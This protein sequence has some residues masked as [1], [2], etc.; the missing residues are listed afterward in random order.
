VHHVSFGN[1]TF[2][3]FIDPSGNT[4]EYT[5]ELEVGD[6]MSITVDGLGIAG[7]DHR[8]TNG[9]VLEQQ[10]ERQPFFPGPPGSAA[11]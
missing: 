2:S 5:T 10:P 3:Y 1:S 4:M 11:P 8:L 9:S 6:R 7:L